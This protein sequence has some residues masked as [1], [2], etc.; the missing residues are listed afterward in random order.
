MGVPGER[1]AEVAQTHSAVVSFAGGCA[2]KLQK[3][4]NLGFLDFSSP[5]AREVACFREVELNRGFA[6]DLYLGV[7]QLRDTAGRHRHC[8]VST[9]RCC[10]I[11]PAHPLIWAQS[12]KSPRKPRNS[13]SEAR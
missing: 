2:F 5:Q 1:F 13:M 8:G 3:L 11:S 10:A 7:A 9:A 12:R 4:V 6:P